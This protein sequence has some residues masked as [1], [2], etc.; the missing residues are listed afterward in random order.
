[1]LLVFSVPGLLAI[2]DA[3]LR[4]IVAGVLCFMIAVHVPVL[5]THRYSVGAV[6]LWLVIA[7][8][9][10]I[11]SLVEERLWRR[12]AALLLLAALGAWAGLEVYRHAAPPAPDIFRAARMRVWDGPAA[13]HV[14]GSRDIPWD[15]AVRDAPRFNPADNHALVIEA[16]LDAA[17][18]KP[19]CGPMQVAYR[20][21]ADAGF[22]PPL[23]VRL[24]E[25]RQVHRYQLG[26]VPIRMNATGVL[27]LQMRC[28]GPT[29]SRLRRIEV[30][31][32]MGG[33][34]YHARLL[35]VPP[36]F[37]LEK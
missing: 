32:P 18:A 2:R 31:S 1:V 17:G 8:A 24:A 6:D 27:R 21:D 16:S 28:A 29:T 23:S 4:W 3:W 34:D 15:I 36:D 25:D 10:G 14:F 26:V 11:A 7:A 30:F 33:I 37:P 22:A 19:S 9:I 20:R 35:H 5:Y 13:D 12:G